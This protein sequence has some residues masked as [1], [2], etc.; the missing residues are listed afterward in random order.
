[1]N[2]EAALAEIHAALK[3]L[4]PEPDHTR[5]VA[6]LALRLFD[7][8]VVLH[9]LGR[10][11]RVILEGAACL[12]DV[13][14]P[15]SDG[16]TAHHKLSARVIRDQEWAQFNRLEVEMLALVARYHRRALPCSEHVDYLRLPK[17]RRDAVRVLAAL[18]RLADAFDRS[19]LQLVRD[20]EVRITERLL[21]ITLISPFPPEREMAAGGKKGNLAAEV[22]GRE[23]LFRYQPTAIAR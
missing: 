17:P 19:H 8:T 3:R 22:F 7:E 6:R 5:H 13:G 14:W 1:V 23:L 20:L 11:E 2:H 16:G 15:L 18:V 9:Q 12:H 4:E 10:D 21:E